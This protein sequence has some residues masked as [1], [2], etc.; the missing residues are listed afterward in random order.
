MA[1][2]PIAADLFEERPVPH[3]VGGRHKESHAFAFPFPAGQEAKNYERVS[4]SPTGRLWSHTVQRFRPKSPP[5]GGPDMFEPY[6]VGYV[7][8]PGEIIVEGRLTGLPINEWRTGMEVRTAIVPFE[9]ADGTV[10]SL[11]AFAPAGTAA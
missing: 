10:V 3:L 5:Y 11:Y 4:L 7:E 8:L 6:A 2:E 1:M 9:R